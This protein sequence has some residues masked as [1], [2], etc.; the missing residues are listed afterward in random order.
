MNKKNN[1]RFIENENIMIDVF[2]ELL[3]KKD[4][5]KI[6]VRDICEQSLVNRSTFYAHFQDIYELKEHTEKRFETE[7]LTS[8]QNKINDSI[9]HKEMIATLI[10]V[11]K[12]KKDFYK[13]YFNGLGYSRMANGFKELI[14]NNQRFHANGENR[15]LVEYQLIFYF[16]GMIAI[17]SRWLNHDCD[18]SEEKLVDMLYEYWPQK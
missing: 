2:I 9:D 4:F 18:L 3:K 8:L 12:E 11:I 17:L 1:L 7:L 10:E 6:T 13:V 14:Q 5:T 15:D 16:D